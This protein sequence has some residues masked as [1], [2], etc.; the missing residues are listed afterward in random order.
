MLAYRTRI[1]HSHTTQ[2]L[3]TNNFI[4]FSLFSAASLTLP[5]IRNHK[6]SHP[7]PLVSTHDP[8]IEL[9]LPLR[10]C[11]SPS[12]TRFQPPPVFRISSSRVT[13]GKHLPQHC[14]DP[15]PHLHTTTLQRYMTVHSTTTKMFRRR[16]SNPGRAGESRV[17]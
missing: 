1:N 6:I 17:S 14:Y 2:T 3:Q 12:T 16:D 7:P 10:L 4:P 15:Y 11:A 13:R 9:S 8:S 5:L